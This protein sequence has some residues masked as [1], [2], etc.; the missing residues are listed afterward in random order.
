[1]IS[2]F[3]VEINALRAEINA[4]QAEIA[5]Y[6]QAEQIILSAVEALHGAIA[7]VNAS[8]PDLVAKFNNSSNS[9]AI[10]KM[11][12]LAGGLRFKPKILSGIPSLRQI[13]R[14][15]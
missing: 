2:L 8:A 4:L 3:Q 11:T 10:M 1:M 14:T 13:L 7:E 15:K 6:E 12:R 5:K 9:R